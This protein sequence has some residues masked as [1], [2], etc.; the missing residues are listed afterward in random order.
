MARPYILL[1]KKCLNLL[2][3]I[4]ALTD[5][6]PG[7]LFHVSLKNL[8]LLRLPLAAV[9]LTASMVPS[10][11]LFFA[12]AMSCII[13]CQMPETQ[14]RASLKP[15]LKETCP[16]QLPSRGEETSDL[17]KRLETFLQREQRDSE[18]EIQAE[19]RPCSQ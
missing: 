5:G 7:T 19:K 13:Q 9:F 12:D 14:K 4:L 10:E 18:G 1:L 11:S 6:L 8:C 17:G 3:Q 15:S 16:R 2:T